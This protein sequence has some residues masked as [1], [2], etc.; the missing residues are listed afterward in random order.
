L[1]IDEEYFKSEEFQE[2]LESYEASI[3]AGSNPFMD[4]DDLVDIADYYNWQGEEE[5][6]EQSINYALELY[7]SSTLPN[8]FK[9][10]KALNSGNY[11]EAHFYADE[12]ADHDDP[13]YHYL[14]AEI[15]IAEGNIDKADLYLRNYEKTVDPDEYEDFVRDCANLYIDYDV[16]EKAYEWMMRSRGDDSDDFKELMARTLF[17]LGKYKD[18]E[19]IFNEL[20]DHHPFSKQYWNAL[21]SAQFMNEDYSNAI[22]SSEF[23]IAI[24]PK[25]PDAVSSK[26]SGL[27]RLGNY[28]EALK[29]FKMYSELEPDDEFGVLHQGVCLVNMNRNDEAMPLLRMALAIAPKDS[30][31]L[32]QIYQELAF[33]YSAK[34]RLKQALEMLDKTETL[35][36]DHIDIQVVRGHILLQNDKV[37][38]AEAAFKKAITQSDNSPAILLRIIISLYDNHYV[39]A[40][41]QMLV[42]FFQMVH[43]YFPDFHNGY[44]YMALCCYDLSR[45][46]EFLK[47]LQLAVDNNPK[48]ARTVLGCLFPESTPVSEYVP[49]M[50]QRLNIEH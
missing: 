25:D 28:E 42:K 16:N 44:A 48:E 21:A 38:E 9:A 30:P 46:K 41:Y 27:F 43:E 32:V 2:L 11:E 18:S 31:L 39:N 24:D 50:E 17:G 45:T 15:M 26:A 37:E 23:A 10:R 35:E 40:C 33:C 34:H 12:I 14:V 6:A 8:V 36:C 49:Y 20:V 7:P 3:N 29:Y 47:Y 1:N 22:T 5:K 4:A 19:R 13:D